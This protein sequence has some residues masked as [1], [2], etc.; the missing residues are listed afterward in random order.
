MLVEEKKIYNK[1]KAD[2]APRS[3]SENGASCQNCS[4][5]VN[6]KLFSKKCTILDMTQVLSSRL[7]T[8]NQCFFRTAK[9]L[10]HRFLKRWLLIPRQDFT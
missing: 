3:R 9:E 5:T 1:C 10:Y 8:I 4:T 7:T 2:S 6:C